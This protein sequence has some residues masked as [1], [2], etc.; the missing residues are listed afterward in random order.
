MGPMTEGAARQDDGVAVSAGCECCKRL[1]NFWLTGEWK[2]PLCGGPAE[3][4]SA[5][6]RRQYVQ[7][8]PHGPTER[9]E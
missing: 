1:M 5:G 4:V 8:N 6:L 7:T 9:A 2:C 3:G